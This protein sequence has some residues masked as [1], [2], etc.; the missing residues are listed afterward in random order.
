[1]Y[2]RA[3]AP[4]LLAAV[5]LC[6]RNSSRTANADILVSSDPL[7]SATAGR[8][9]LLI[10]LADNHPPVLLLRADA[11]NIGVTPS[12]SEQQAHPNFLETCRSVIADGCCCVYAYLY[13]TYDAY[14]ID[15]FLGI[16]NKADSVSGNRVPA[17]GCATPSGGGASVPSQLLPHSER[18]YSQNPIFKQ[19]IFRY[20]NRTTSSLGS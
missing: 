7:V 2:L 10:I 6:R 3:V 4:L 1:V 14:L 13:T 16:V 17:R 19:V 5:L 9:L 20:M 11:F 18:R 12:W 8:E 15:A